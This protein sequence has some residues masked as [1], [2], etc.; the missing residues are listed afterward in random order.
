MVSNSRAFGMTA[1]AFVIGVASTNLVMTSW[2]VH[3]LSMSSQKSTATA[4]ERSIA[5]L[6]ENQEKDDTQD[7]TSTNNIDEKTVV[8]PQNQQVDVVLPRLLA[9][10]V[11]K[12]GHDYEKAREDYTKTFYDLAAESGTDKVS[13]EAA[14][15]GHNYQFAYDHYLPKL[16]HFPLRFLEI[17][18]GCDLAYGP[19]RSLDVWDRY[20]THAHAKIVFIEEDHECAA[21][22]DGKRPRIRVDAG[23]AGDSGFLQSFIQK[24]NGGNFDV[25]VDDGSHVCPDQ[26]LT[27]LHLFPTLRSGGLY[28]LE[29]L[30]TSYWAKPGGGYLKETSTIEYIKRMMDAFYGHGPAT[31]IIDQVRSIHCFHEMCVFI[32]K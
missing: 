12:E 26:I 30:Q 18:L 16:R 29:D 28:F 13:T 8:Q 6:T 19:G 1:V 24:H 3:K 31:E 22:W 27:L 5:R 9:V 25:I 21:Q 15:A 14:P 11:P 10:E 23:D 32:K 17:G 2:Y 4:Q 7:T 20:F